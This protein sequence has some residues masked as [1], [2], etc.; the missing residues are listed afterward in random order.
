MPAMVVA[1]WGSVAIALCGAIFAPIEDWRAIA[2]SDLLQLF[3]AAI[4]V[5]IAIYLLAVGFRDVDLSVVAPFRYTY[6]LTSALGGYLVFRELPD[7]WTVAGAGLIVSS[8][9]YTLHREAVRRR[10]L[11]AKTAAAL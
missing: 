4:F 3:I 2:G 6:L 7:A 9:I 8:G 1:F 5:G 11:T 10:S